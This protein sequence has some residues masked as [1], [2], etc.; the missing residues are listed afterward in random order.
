MK[1]IFGLSAVL[2]LLGISG[3]FSAVVEDWSS[4]D[5]GKI[6]GLIWTATVPKLISLPPRV[7]RAERRFN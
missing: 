3:A 5:P 6:P 7:P 2:F 4:I 1:K